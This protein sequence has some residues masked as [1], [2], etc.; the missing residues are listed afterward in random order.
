MADV[1]AN[2]CARRK[3]ARENAACAL[4]VFGTIAA[5]MLF[6][7]G[8]VRAE[9]TTGSVDDTRSAPRS[10]SHQERT[11]VDALIAWLTSPACEVTSTTACTD[12][13]V[14]GEGQGERPV[15]FALS[16]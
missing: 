4:V 13:V 9:S 15:E 1:I 7:S 14:P 2:I 6:D 16:E 5:V 8:S 3:W 10:S 11:I 12:A